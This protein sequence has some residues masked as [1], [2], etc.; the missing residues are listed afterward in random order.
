MTIKILNNSSTDCHYNLNG[1]AEHRLFE[2]NCCM[3]NEAD[4]KISNKA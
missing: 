2:Q 3:L 4:L 1:I